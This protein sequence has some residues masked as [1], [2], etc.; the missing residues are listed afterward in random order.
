M[1]MVFIDFFNMQRLEKKETAIKRYVLQV[2]VDGNEKERKKERK[3]IHLESKTQ[4]RK[5]E[6]PQREDDIIYMNYY[7]RKS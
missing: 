7:T 4:E 5:G 2:E 6:N 3:R 1:T